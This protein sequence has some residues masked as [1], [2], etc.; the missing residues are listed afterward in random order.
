MIVNLRR[1]LR[2][3]SSGA[4]LVQRLLPFS[5]SEK[6][7]IFEVATKLFLQ[8]QV[9][10]ASILKDVW[11]L[12]EVP[13]EVRR[14]LRLPG[15]DEGIDLIARTHQGEYWAIQVKY[16]SDYDQ[17]LTRKE[18]ATFT[19]LASNTCQNIA[20]AVVVHTCTKPIGKRDLLRNTVEIGLDRW[21]EA[22]WNL[23]VQRLKGK[24]A[25]PKPR[26]PYRY[27]A[28]AIAAA[29][30]HF[31]KEKER[32]G[33]IIMPCGTGKSLIA[34]W[35]C[36]KLEAE[37]VAVLVPSLSLIRQGVG[38]WAREFL[39]KKKTPQWICVQRRDGRAA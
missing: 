4:E 24:A 16:R 23:I 13:A 12:D 19:S 5:N 21:R 9:P 35:I 18:I 30:K 6:G 34:H 10:Y 11:L 31:I 39:A 8:T 17:P 27:Q 38:D 37:T 26:H 33:R 28:P 20:L 36:E 2:T 29:K 15:R 3:I 1:F 22:D 32:R 14:E 7:R 25:R